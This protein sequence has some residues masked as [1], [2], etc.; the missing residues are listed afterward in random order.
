[1]PLKLKLAAHESLIVNGAVLVNGEYRASLIIRNFT[2]VMREKDVLRE[3]DADTPTRRLYFIIQTMLMQPPPP[4]NLVR[5]YNEL[6]TQ[7]RD[8]FVRPENL[9][10]LKTVNEL[11]ESGDYYKAL[12]GLHPLIA[13]EANLLNVAPHEWRRSAPVSFKTHEAGHEA[14]SQS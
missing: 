10:I 3:A 7:L 8:A 13:Y 2:H 9:E 1:M 11:V 5:T 4:P 6:F 14:I 12:A